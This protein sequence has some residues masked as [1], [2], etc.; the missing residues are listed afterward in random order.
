MAPSYGEKSEF[1]VAEN[2]LRVNLAPA[3]AY[4]FEIDTPN[5][6]KQ[7]KGKAYR[8]KV[9]DKKKQSTL[10]KDGKITTNKKLVVI[11]FKFKKLI[12]KL[13]K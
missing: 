7:S 13:A 6:Q 12:K 9:A 11:L 1:Q 8:Q 2:E 5:I 10:N 4:V 3:G